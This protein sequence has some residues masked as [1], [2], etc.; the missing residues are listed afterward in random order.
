M[1][2]IIKRQGRVPEGAS[3]NG[4]NPDEF[5]SFDSLWEGCPTT[6]I[7][8]SL[9]AI[10]R[11]KEEAQRQA[12]ELIKKA[13]AEVSRIES[14]AYQK[15]YGQGEKDGMA[16][17][18]K[19]FE[20]AVHQFE[21]VLAE[22]EAQRRE[23]GLRYEEDNLALI[24][25]LVE[26]LIFQEISLHPRII[27]ACL[28]ASLEYTV[29]NSSVRVHLSPDDFVLLRESG[30]DAASLLGG[31]SRIDLIEDPAITPGGCLLESEF[32]EVDA[33]V[34]GRY[35]RLYEVL[36]KVFMEGRRADSR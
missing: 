31:K 34:E 1:S 19:K 4:L 8:D 33:T 18:K 36:D 13:K 21:R 17:G 9:G 20:V 10:R 3:P 5:T 26:R 30:F 14:E 35:E 29:D 28:N 15:G 7:I 27:M 6:G 16:F 24:K 22:I 12:D 11:K 32:G 25:I 2:S 23:L